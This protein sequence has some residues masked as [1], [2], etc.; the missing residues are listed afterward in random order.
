[1]ATNKPRFSVTFTEDAFVRIQKY[2]KENSISTQSKAVAQLV[3]LAI[4]EIDAESKI[5][6]PPSDQLADGV[7]VSLE[8][9]NWHVDA[10]KKNVPSDLSEEAL[11]VAKDY[12]D[13][14][15][16]G[17]NVVKVVLSEEGKRIKAEKERRRLGPTES[18]D[19]RF[20]PL[21]YTPAAAGYTEPAAG[22]DFDYIEVGP[23]VPRRADCAIKISGKSMEPYVKDKS[24]VYVTREPIENG[25]V[26][27][28]CVDGDI[29]C[30]QYFR[31]ENGRVRLLSLNRD[32][33]D[34]DRIIYPKDTDTIMTY[35]GKVL[36]D[37]R[38]RIVI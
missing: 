15:Q 36:M 14:D 22:Q 33:S 29:L 26:G 3:S 19:T 30:K 13:L 16:P 21:Y 38:P 12:S 28:F 6:N 9:L 7:D 5:E 37:H 31:E 11:Q 24:I 23:E 25:D 2:Q 4:S 18:S 8:R 32:Y 17:K 10:A 20:I 35:Y 27:I 1:M 34:A